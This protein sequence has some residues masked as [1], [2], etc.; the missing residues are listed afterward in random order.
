MKAPIVTENFPGTS[1]LAQNLQIAHKTVD[2]NKRKR[3][4]MKI[5]KE[6]TMKG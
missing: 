3:F 1:P 4:N 5:R 2:H 6:K